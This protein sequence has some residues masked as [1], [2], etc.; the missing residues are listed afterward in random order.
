MTA[1]R[2]SWRNLVLFV[3][4]ECLLLLI[5]LELAVRLTGLDTRLLKPLL[6]YQGWDQEVYRVS[7]DV[8]LHYELK[9]GA[10]AFFPPARKVTINSLGF[11]GR[12]RSW[13]K[14]KGVFRIVCLGGSNTYGASVSDGETYP[15]RLEAALNRL[16]RGRFEVWN[17]GACARVLSQDVQVARQIVAHAEPDLLVFQVSNC[18]RRPFLIDAPFQR[19][20]DQDPTLYAEN[21]KYLPGSGP[22]QASL[23]RHWR[24]YRALV[25]GANQLLDSPRRKPCTEKDNR[26]NLEAVARFYEE[27][28]GRVP[29]VLLI[30][31]RG[32]VDSSLAFLGI[33]AIRLGRKLAKKH[34]HDY[35]MIHPP[36]YVYRWYADVILAELDARGLLPKGKG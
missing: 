22:A 1:G 7:D 35:D 27:F 26:F 25:L 15:A 2:S 6:Y 32:S 13:K 10:S 18:G 19:Y 20:F 33:G 11:R 8:V 28:G 14:P 30:N 36:P 9:P 24:F 12:E 34:P 4:V 17:A 29:M 21:L 23:M 31:P 5:A 16:S 3:G